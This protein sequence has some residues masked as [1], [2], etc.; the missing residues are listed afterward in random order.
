MTLMLVIYLRLLGV[1]EPGQLRYPA[2]GA[3]VF[4]IEAVSGTS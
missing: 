2:C 1:A 4:P 3:E